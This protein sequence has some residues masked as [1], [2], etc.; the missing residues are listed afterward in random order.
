MLCEG[1]N[2]V[3]VNVRGRMILIRI[4]LPMFFRIKENVKVGKKK[5]V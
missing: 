4:Q 3:A 1:S 2:I 5:N